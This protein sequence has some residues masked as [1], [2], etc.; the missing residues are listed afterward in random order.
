MAILSFI[1]YRNSIYSDAE[2]KEPNPQALRHPSGSNLES[3]AWG[4]EPCL[5]ALLPTFVVFCFLGKDVRL[6][7]CTA[8]KTHPRDESVLRKAACF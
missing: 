1:F 7:Y 6:L 3:R 8:F 2:P 4:R 5:Q